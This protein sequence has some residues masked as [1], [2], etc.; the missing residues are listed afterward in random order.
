M[1][2]N[3]I[4]YLDT[5]IAEGNKAMISLHNI[6]DTMLIQDGNNPDHI[7]RT[8][9]DDF[10]LKYSKELKTIRKYLRIDEQYYYKPKMVAE[11]LY[12]TT[13]LWIALLRCNDMR[14]IPEFCKP[15]I[16]IYNPNDLDDLIRV[17]FK[18]E[19]KR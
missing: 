12:G 19:G 4:V 3:A 9:F 18:R 10:F 2:N 5:F 11:M 13:E 17:F 7:Y 1:T 15:I 16:R 14:T 6:Y 8:A